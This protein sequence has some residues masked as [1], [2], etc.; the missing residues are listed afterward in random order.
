MPRGAAAESACCRSHSRL[1]G[2]PSA[3]STRTGASTRPGGSWPAS[4]TR[5][6]PWWRGRQSPLRTPAAVRMCRRHDGKCCRH[7]RVIRLQ[8]FHRSRHSLRRPCARASAATARGG[9]G[10][11]G[12]GVSAP[13]DALLAADA[14]SV[15]CVRRQDVGARCLSRAEPSRAVPG[16]VA[17]QPRALAPTGPGPGSRP[18]PS[19]S[20]APG[21]PTPGHSERPEPPSFTPDFNAPR[22]GRGR[23]ASPPSARRRDRDGSRLS[24]TAEK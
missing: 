6:W 8:G 12:E 5:Q 7:G 23:R 3:G 4:C 22:V 11:G 16:P 14:G 15:P 13:V 2:A 10:C 1:P 9:S 20:R 21:P 19:W 17:S 24:A 18:S